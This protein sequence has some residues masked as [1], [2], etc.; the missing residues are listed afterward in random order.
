MLSLVTYVFQYKSDNTIV[1]TDKWS[2]QK[3]SKETEE[4]NEEF[5]GIK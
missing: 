4:G 2:S 5:Y 1:I 3:L